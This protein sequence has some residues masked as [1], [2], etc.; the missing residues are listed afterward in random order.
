MPFVAIVKGAKRTLNRADDAMGL[1]HEKNI[2][3]HQRVALY[4]ETVGKKVSR[5]DKAKVDG[6]SEHTEAAVQEPSAG[7]EKL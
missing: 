2:H 5:K 3:A 1:E 6:T 7:A 4:A